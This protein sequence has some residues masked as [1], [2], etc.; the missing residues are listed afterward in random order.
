MRVPQKTVALASAGLVALS[1]SACGTEKPAGSPAGDAGAQAEVAE[2]ATA[3]DLT[4]LATQMQA[5]QEKA[6]TSHLE[7]TY[8]G[9]L[10]DAAGMSESTTSADLSYGAT[11]EES[12]MHMSMAVMGTDM[13]IVLVDGTIYLSMG[14]MTQGKYL[15]LTME[16]MADDPAMAG[17][18]DSM[19]SMDAA[20]QAEAMADAVTSF[21]HTGTERVGDLET[22]VYSVTLDPAKIENGAAGVDASTAAQVGEMTVVYKVAPEGLPVQADITMEV[23]GQEM[24]VESSFSR[25]GEPV[26]IT[27]PADDEVVPYKEFGQG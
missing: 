10:A 17:T 27:A 7:L 19:E 8:A 26:D 18:F 11:L 23:A 22:E 4:E 5:A 6:S 24:V 9:E 25:W 15:S 2:V 1:L 21:E 20:A 12:S 3:A 14:E 16:E 13:D